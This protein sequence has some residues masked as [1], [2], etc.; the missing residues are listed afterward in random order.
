[1]ILFLV[2]LLGFGAGVLVTLGLQR[3]RQDGAAQTESPSPEPASSPDLPEP[4]ESTEPA[5]TLGAKLYRLSTPLEI[6]ADSTA[7]PNQLAEKAEF[8]QASA[9]LVSPD[10]PIETVT[11]YALGTNWTLACAALDALRQRPDRDHPDLLVMNQMGRLRPWP[12]HYALEYFLSLDERLPVGAAVVDAEAW[13]AD[14]PIIPSLF[15]SYFTKL[16]ALGDA[17][18]FGTWLS[19]STSADPQQIEL[20]LKS[21]SHPIADALIAEMKAQKGARVDRTYLE[22]IGRFWA[23]DLDKEP[24]IEPE[25]WKTLLDSAERSIRHS[26]PRSLIIRGDAKTGK[27]SFLKILAQRLSV[28]HWSVFEAGGPELQA[29]QTYIGQL[30]ERVKRLSQEAVAA[31]QI[32]WYV[33]DILQLAMGGTHQ[34]QP[35]SILDQLYGALSSGSI[36]IISEATPQQITQLVQLKPHLKNLFEAVPLNALSETRTLELVQG[37]VTEMESRQST[38]FDPEAA[39]L[40]LQLARQYLDASQLPGSVFDL[41][42]LAFNHCRSMGAK[43]VTPAEIMASLSQVTGLPRAILDAEEK[44]ELATVRRFFDARVMGQPEAVQRIVDRIAM[45]KAGLTDPSKPIGVFLFA[46]PTGTGKTELAKTLAQFLFSSADRMIRLD[47]SEYKGHDSISKIIG[48]AGQNAPRS[49]FLINQVRKQP[50]SVV[51]LDEFEKAH[52]NIWDLF[53]QVFDD[54]R[55]T[56][57]NGNAADFR[58]CIIILTSNL[59]ATTHENSGLGFGART[60]AFSPEQIERAIGQAFRPEFI[61]RLDKVI[62]FQPLSRALMRQILHKELR[63]VLDRRGLRNREWAV[64]WEESAIEFLLDKGFSAQLG[65]RPLKRAVDEYLLAP[66]AATIVEHRVPEGDQFLFVRS[67][68]RAIQVE[69]VDP[70]ADRNSLPATPGTGEVELASIVLQA[71]GTDAER[72]LLAQE[73]RLIDLR[74]GSDEW[75]AQAVALGQEMAQEDFWRLPQ[76]FEKLS[77]LALMDRIKAAAR[78]ADAMRERLDKS[79]N[80]SGSYSGELMGRLARQIFAL[81]AGIA[82]ALTGAPVETVVRVEPA[83]D[84]MGDAAGA[85]AW[86]TQLLDM[87]RQWAKRR[88]MQ[89]AEHVLDGSIYLLVSGFGAHRTLSG[90]SGL[91][92][93]ETGDED[94]ATSR[95]VARVRVVASP[96]G[97][98]KA[99]RAALELKR[100]IEASAMPSQIMR[101]YR[102]GDAALVRDARLGWRSGKFDQI[103]DGD[104]DLIGATATRT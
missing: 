21:L 82:D 37:Y 96:P 92:V 10:V 100:V 40:A 6:F 11:Q 72:G 52:P 33:P 45:L 60:D 42:K 3:Q 22:T 69:F 59:G 2:L 84:A 79:R 43:L 41:V 13:W 98:L 99:S 61:N 8:Q 76:R 102:G 32:I 14:N 30:E 74:L 77:R 7:H 71:H 78:T 70:D 65:A 85:P 56:D 75:Q 23:S 49:D 39:P 87:Y 28:K 104:F 66:L 48:E 101:R 17:P 50:F 15:Q 18:T 73:Q 44:V 46:G 89:I 88:G 57:A 68:G 25:E 62:V 80:K 97:E 64:E 54:G 24:V 1:M 26:P 35:A 81:K 29:G 58:H 95:V 94:S 20:F 91:H 83:L 53:L 38:R 47:M 4:D 67:D 12:L 27:T 93:L 9:L 55:L 90:E 31:K 103:L 34:S 36:I 19:M 63:N 51:L 16:Q 86:C 5:D